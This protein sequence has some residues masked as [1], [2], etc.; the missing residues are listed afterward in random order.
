MAMLFHPCDMI[1]AHIASMQGLVGQFMPDDSR[2][3]QRAKLTTP[4]WS[5]TE[6]Q[7][8]QLNEIFKTVKTPTLGMRQAL[9]EQLRVSPRQIQVWFRNRRQR[10][11][12]SEIQCGSV[13]KPPTCDDISLDPLEAVSEGDFVQEDDEV[14]QVT[15]EVS[16]ATQDTIDMLNKDAN[17]AI[18]EQRVSERAISPSSNTG[19]TV[20]TNLV[21][22]PPNK[23]EVKANINALGST[24][25]LHLGQAQLQPAQF[26]SAQGPTM[27]KMSTGTAN[28][29][30]RADAMLKLAQME[31]VI[32]MQRHLLLMQ[33]HLFESLVKRGGGR[34][35]ATAP[36]I[37]PMASDHLEA[38]LMSALPSIGGGDETSE[39]LNLSLDDLTAFLGGPTE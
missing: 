13:T 1:E 30:E 19:S 18:G 38:S 24:L 6:S 23:V 14:S 29:A 9:A 20:S 15:K 5:I 8:A 2:Q 35:A 33:N 39:Q 12:L 27:N 17:A 7:L 10:V 37:P 28:P 11:R 3:R 4:R 31:R 21:E 25:L 36:M 22:T 16:Q 34:S 26:Q 32:T